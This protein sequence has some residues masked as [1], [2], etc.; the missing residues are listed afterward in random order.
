MTEPTNWVSLYRRMPE[1]VREQIFDVED[2]IM[3]LLGMHPM[4]RT[5]RGS[6]EVEQVGKL[7][8]VWELLSASILLMD[9]E[10]FEANFGIEA[11]RRK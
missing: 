5:G 9:D 3:A 6:S 7:V 2:R 1:P 4:P 11:R 10:T 8:A